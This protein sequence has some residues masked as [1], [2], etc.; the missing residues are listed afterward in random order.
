M[1]KKII[2][3]SLGPIATSIIGLVTTPLLAWILTPDDM[4]R[5]A[6][7]HLISG[8]ATLVLT[9][10]LDQ[11]FMRHYYKS[12]GIMNICLFPTI[13]FVL[14]ISILMLNNASTINIDVFTLTTS[15]DLLICIICLNFFFT[16]I[17]RYSSLCLRMEDKALYF[18]ISQIITKIVI[19]VQLSIL[20]LLDF[21][22]SFLHVVIV[23]T[24]STL[25][26]LIYTTC[27]SSFFSE[28]LTFRLENHLSFLSDGLKFGV[29][30]IISGVAFWLLTGLDK[31]M[32]KNYSTLS[33]LAIYSVAVSFSS[34]A[35]ILKSVFGTIWMP[36][37]YK[38]EKNQDIEETKTLLSNVIP[39]VAFLAIM[40]FCLIGMASP[41]IKLFLP[42][43]YDKVSLIITCCCGYP[44]FYTL[45]ESCS[46]GLY[47][48][49]KT[50]VVSIISI[51]TVF[52]NFS[53]NYYLI[54]ILGAQGAAVST[55]I[56][57][58]IYYLVRS[59]VSSILWIRISCK[60][61]YLFCF[62]AMKV[63]VL[64][65]LLLNNTQSFSLWT[66]LLVLTLISYKREASK[67]FSV[68]ISPK[69]G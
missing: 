3:Y 33:D 40:V 5:I 26:T 12:K 56:S 28:L 24:I 62:L 6:M 36:L 13:L 1:K 42:E 38:S 47:I 21:E 59:E 39:Q 20:F 23:Y 25:C 35:V 51:F 65:S 55:L 41:L 44:L 15:T 7:F 11:Y 45:S 54:P 64:Q 29:P 58:F 49:N 67:I 17:N 52:I 46:A 19:V 30:L 61:D 37:I 10:G 48:K 9:L 2:S 14:M 8:L 32:L 57:F 22:V 63:S 18:S 50:H 68:I 31:L 69:L 60:K 43:H 34:F 16:I 27:N 66:L 53:L 4:G